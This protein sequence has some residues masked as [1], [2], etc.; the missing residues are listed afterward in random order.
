M[1]GTAGGTEEALE[2]QNQQEVRVAVI[3]LEPKQSEGEACF[4][5]VEGTAH[6]SVVDQ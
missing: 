4:V 3:S 5:R 6:V 1:E 2:L